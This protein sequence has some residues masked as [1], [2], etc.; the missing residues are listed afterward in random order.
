MVYADGWAAINLEM[1]PRV[2]RTEY[3][4][5]THWRLIDAVTGIHV[6]ENSPLEEQQAAGRAFMREW[7]YCFAWSTLTKSMSSS[8][9][10]FLR[11]LSS[12]Q[13]RI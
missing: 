11:P 10:S 13:R 4:A 7:E 5:H 1:P 9:C 8:D 3:S 12:E 6:D 2:P